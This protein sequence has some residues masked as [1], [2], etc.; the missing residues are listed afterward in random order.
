MGV[1]A[2]SA[3][4]ETGGGAL[5]ADVYPDIVVGADASV[6]LGNGA[7][8]EADTKRADANGG[9]AAVAETSAPLDCDGCGDQSSETTGGMPDGLSKD[10]VTDI[11]DCGDLDIAT[12]MHVDSAGVP[13]AAAPG[14]A[15]G[16]VSVDAREICKG[17]QVHPW[18]PETLP[19]WCESAIFPDPWVWNESKQSLYLQFVQNECPNI[20][21]KPEATIDFSKTTVVYAWLWDTSSCLVYSES[22]KAET[23]NGVVHLDIEM[24]VLEVLEECSDAGWSET[25]IF[26]VEAAGLPV[27]VFVDVKWPLQ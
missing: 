10:G 16:C 11:P 6:D 19:Q 9:D 23:C 22:V 26:A 27:E 12:D 7:G 13:D 17:L 1:S 3:V 5:D 21:G 4:A 14:D 25:G 24:T 18:C 15:D 2:D 8:G 20:L